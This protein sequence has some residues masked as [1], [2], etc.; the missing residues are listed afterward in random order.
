MTAIVKSIGR[1]V[2]LHPRTSPK[3]EAARTTTGKMTI[4][5]MVKEV[6]YHLHLE[7][8]IEQ[9]RQEMIELAGKHGLA[10]DLVLSVSQQLDRYIVIAQNRINTVK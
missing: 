4:R 6:G 5:G 3:R 7:K 2:P 8:K 9:L 1:D 10:N